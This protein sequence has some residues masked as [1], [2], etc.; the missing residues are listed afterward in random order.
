MFLGTTMS[1]FYQKTVNIPFE[2][3]IEKVTTGLKEIGFGVVAEI[4][5]SELLKEKI[6]V[7]MKPYK[8]LGACNPNLAY[9]AIQIEERIGLLLPCNVLVREIDG[10]EV[11]ISVIDPTSMIMPIKNPRL[12][13]FAYQ[14]NE[15]LKK[16]IQ[17]F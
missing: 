7:E 14:V 16:F 13:D 4:P 2:E 8:I 10:G 5:V 15:M 17:N 11:E 6:G 1:Y 3:A 9:R 12:D